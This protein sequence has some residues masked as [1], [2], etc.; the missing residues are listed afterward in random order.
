MNRRVLLGFVLAYLTPEALP[1][2]HTPAPATDAAAQAQPD[3][4]LSA[5]SLHNS[6]GSP[7]V[8]AV[9][10]LV[11]DRFDVDAL[12]AFTPV[13]VWTGNN[14]M[15]AFRVERNSDQGGVFTATRAIV[16]GEL[17]WVSSRGGTL[18]GPL[19]TRPVKY[20]AITSHIGVREHPLRKQ[21]KWHAGTDFGA[22]IGA[23]V[24][25]V[26]D[27]VIL[28][29]GRDWHAGNFVVVTHD[30]G[31]ETRYLHLDRKVKG[32]AAGVR[33]TKGELLGFV[34]KT[35]RVTGPHL[36][37]EMRDH[38]GVPLDAARVQGAAAGAITD[39]SQLRTLSDRIAVLD[40]F[41]RAQS[42]GATALFATPY[43]RA[44]S[45][46]QRDPVRSAAWEV[47]RAPMVASRGARVLS[48]GTAAPAWRRRI[49]RARGLF[50]NVSAADLADPMARRTLELAAMHELSLRALSVRLG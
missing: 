46:L 13:T 42:A 6:M 21:L 39:A 47:W 2:N 11:A 22:S 3:V 45:T 32:I 40:A 35:G 23:A 12:A 30:I 44:P 16:D 41:A 50:D 10:D 33:V 20:R 37:Y 15:V 17:L 7:W 36:H 8:R 4:V 31:I 25:A 5:L 27:G 34:G 18:S 28:R 43:F 38:D 14:E 48:R 29:E 26:A 9:R 24:V 1:C 19:S 49:T